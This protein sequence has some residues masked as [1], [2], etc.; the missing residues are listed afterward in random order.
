MANWMP[1]CQ[2]LTSDKIA[3][4]VLVFY[5]GLLNNIIEFDDLPMLFNGFISNQKIGLLINI[6]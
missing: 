6:Y 3:I 5:N 4:K 2:H 1:I